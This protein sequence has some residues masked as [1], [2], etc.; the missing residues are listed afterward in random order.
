MTAPRHRPLRT[1]TRRDFAR[2]AFVLSTAAW[3]GPLFVPGH[4]EAMARTR[5][6][7]TAPAGTTLERSILTT[8]TG[9][10]FDLTFGPGW[11]LVVRGELA[12]PK[13]GREGRRIALTAF[14][15]TTDYQFPDVQSPARVEFLDRDA[16]DPG[17]SEV[18]GAFR[19][20]EALVIHATE[21]VHRRVNTIAVG[22]VTGRP[23]DF[24]M[25][26]GDNFDNAQLN[27]LEWFLTLMNGGEVRPN[28]GD[29]DVFESVQS[30][31]EPAF[32][33]PHYYHPERVED[34]RGSD[35]YKRHF[36]FPDY[37]GLLAAAGAPF[38]AV[39]IDTPW[40]S[41]WGNHD[42]LVQGNERPNPVYQAIA[43]GGT[44]ILAPPPGLA[45][46]DFMRGL[47]DQDPTVV[48]LIHLAPARPVGADPARRFITAH[49]YI[50]YHLKAGGRPAGH[51]FTED[52]L[53]QQTLYYTFDI[54][55]RILGIGLD[56]T[57]PRVNL[58]SIGE[59]QLAWLEEQLVAV[60]SRHVDR[61]GT[62]V[63]SSNEDRLVVVFSHHRESSMVPMQ[64]PDHAGRLE[65]RYG[66]DA[67]R[68]L[69]NRFPNVIAWVNGHSHVNRVEPRPDPQGRTG[70]YWDITT[71]AQ[72]DPP[73]QARV[74]E[75]ADNR[76]GTLSILTTI[77]DHAGPPETAVGAY[78]VEGLAAI[79][80]ELAFNDYQSDW[81]HLL[82]TPQDLNVELLLA[83]P[84][85]VTPAAGA[86]P[87][88]APEPEPAPLPATGGGLGGVAVG[89][90][91][92]GAATALRRRGQQD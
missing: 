47:A 40:Y 4:R 49:D 27:E 3:A 10:Y 78:D 52:N 88:Q 71:S 34:P 50:D 19:P 33:D 87:Q 51:G 38:T 5:D 16:D 86:P 30:F 70:G 46:A 28:S 58:G 65:R 25:C 41:I 18:S 67:V 92:I 69:L 77:F 84:F 23:L 1:M 59:T 43:T 8:G 80:R 83:A 39:G 73:Q 44:K 22:P 61:G 89:A 12:A 75:V 37:P 31:D 42:A 82:G 55:P 24:T 48:A 85:D 45:P 56:T 14:L 29:P 32:Y 13:T 72:I 20:Q 60:H 53:D 2:R 35:I 63:R 90:L 9:P 26:T 11:P 74:I 76:D 6:T 79:S 54:A 7:V 36:G 57:S 15:H 81:E 66:G 68:E 21:A 17:S 62:E 64:G 91:A